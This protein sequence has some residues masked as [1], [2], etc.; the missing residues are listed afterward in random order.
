MVISSHDM[1]WIVTFHTNTSNKVAV[2]SIMMRT[3]HVRNP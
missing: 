1:V 3:Y 2:L